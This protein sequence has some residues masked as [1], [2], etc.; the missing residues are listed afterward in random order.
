MST[1]KERGQFYTKN[2]FYILDGIERPSGP[3]VEPFAGEGDLIEWLGRPAEA[4]DIDPKKPGTIRQDTLINPPDYTGR[5]VLTNPPYL[6]RNHTEVKTLF[7]KYDTNDLYKCFIWSLCLGSPAE[8]GIVIIP[9]GFFLSPRTVDAKCR[10]AFMS[11]Y[12][13]LKVKYF[14]EP[15]FD[16]TTTTVVVVVF[17]RSSLPISEQNIEWVRMP[18][19]DSKVF[20]VKAND[21][22]IIG[23]SVYRLKGPPGVKI[24][25]YVESTELRP[26]EQ[27]TNLWLCAL[28]GTDRIRLEFRE[29]NPYPGKDTSRTWA[30]LTI[31]GRNLSI[32]EQKR[33]VKLFNDFLEQKRSE[34][35]SL[36]L[37][38]YREYDRKRIPFDLAYSMFGSILDSL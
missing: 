2:S 13:V 27:L 18:R 16:D 38:Q 26:R 31:E 20:T 21:N 6:A 17:E 32:L 22:W 30:T 5:W 33:S 15:V 12:K 1:K 28:D 11:R 9:A 19:G 37:P 7:N 34:T 36:F 35:W 23:G 8:G 25:R 24:R 3:V 14:E 4:Y 29:G 10:N